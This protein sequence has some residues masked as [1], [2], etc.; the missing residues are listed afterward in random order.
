MNSTNKLILLLG[1]SQVGKTCLLSKLTKDKT[2]LIYKETYGC[3]FTNFELSL[4]NQ[5]LSLNI[6]DSYGDEDSVTIIPSKIYKQVS[7]FIIVC[8]YS[9]RSSLVNIKK[10]LDHIRLYIPE[11]SHIPIIVLLNKC[12]LSIKQFTK[13]EG[14]FYCKA[15]DLPYV[16]EISIYG[17]VRNLFYKI[18]EL[19]IGKAYCRRKS[20]VSNTSRISLSNI[21]ASGDKYFEK[22]E[23]ETNFNTNTN[24]TSLTNLYNNQSMSRPSF[25]YRYSDGKGR[26]EEIR[27]QQKSNCC[28]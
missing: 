8:S 17:N 1:D 7:C 3:D 11:D 21:L 5:S 18:S 16:Y 25:E 9:D 28:F 2:E 12:D 6:W 13:E 14:Y 26:I 19:L 23:S 15:F 4:Y 10:W 22:R 24:E 27:P 20:N